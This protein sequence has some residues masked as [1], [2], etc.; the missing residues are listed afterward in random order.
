VRGFLAEMKTG[1]FNQSKW[2]SSGD[3][4]VGRGNYLKFSQNSK[5]KGIPLSTC[6]KIIVETSPSDRIWGVGFDA[7]HAEG[8]EEQWGANK[9]GEA[10]MR[11]RNRLEG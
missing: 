7:E 3:E 8:N 11:F 5:L 2:D 9:L 6:T 4:I 1:P 10:L